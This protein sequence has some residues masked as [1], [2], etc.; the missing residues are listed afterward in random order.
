MAFEN[1]SSYV[2]FKEDELSEWEFISAIAEEA[3]TY[4]LLDV[5]NV[6]VNSFNHK[7]DPKEFILNV[8]AHRVVQYHL[9]GHS[10]FETFLFDTH[11]HDIIEPVWELFRYTLQTVGPRPFIIERDD[12]IP[13]LQCVEVEAQRAEQEVL[14]TLNSRNKKNAGPIKGELSTPL[15]V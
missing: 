4:L 14:I 3:D 11:D 7:F 15:S 1:I 12:K 10:D 5:N 2:R 6:Y 13:P 8:P 9:A